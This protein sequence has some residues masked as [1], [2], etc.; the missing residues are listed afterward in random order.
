MSIVFDARKNADRSK[1]A[2]EAGART[3]Q[4]PATAPDSPNPQNAAPSVPATKPND[5]AATGAAATAVANPETSSRTLVDLK[6]ERRT[7]DWRLLWNRSCAA[8]AIRGRLSIEDG[9]ARKQL[10]LDI[11]ELQTGSIVY[12]PVTN[13][14]FFRLEIIRPH[15]EEALTESVRVVAGGIAA[16][17][18]P[19]ENRRAPLTERNGVARIAR[20][21]GAWAPGMEMRPG[22]GITNETAQA[23]APLVRSLL[24]T[25]YPQAIS[26]VMGSSV[27]GSSVRG[28]SAPAPSAPVPSPRGA[29]VANSSAK[30]SS[31][32]AS[33]IR[34]EAN[35][36]EENDK[37]E[38]A[39]L[40]ART[41][42]V[43]PAIARQ[44]HISGSVE[45]QFRISP[46]GR[47]YDVKS[48]KGWPILA[49]AA[50]EAVATWRYEPARRN[51]R[52]VESQVRT[53]FDFQMS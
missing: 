5:P 34:G 24:R 12:A 13:E 35:L 27:P 30:G 37:I 45:V 48:L 50:M 20:S 10:D 23:D 41:D 28:P 29:S 15:P 17:S 33:S 11:A 46:E 1:R 8:N 16:Q 6:A 14:V 52:P 42:P 40:I 18:S 2:R 25:P 21:S 32:P 47:V 39:T 44:S 38:P 43:Y 31:I 9:A 4:L 53:N 7:T 49:K 22:T 26:S 3:S 51:G 19:E 36:G